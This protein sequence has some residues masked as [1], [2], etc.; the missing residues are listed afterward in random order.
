MAKARGDFTDILLRKKIIGPDQLADAE[1]YAN[2]TGIKLQ[3][4]IVKQGYASAVEVMS[5]IA[6]QHGMQF[7]DLSELEIAKAVIELVPESV[8]REN[9][10]IPLSLE[11]N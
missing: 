7:V 11:G 2:T 10:V 9:V 6:E 1:N 4:A 5:A 3:D 8:A